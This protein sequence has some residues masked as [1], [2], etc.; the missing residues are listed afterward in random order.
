[1]QSPVNHNLLS[2]ME[3][4]IAPK[5]RMESLIMGTHVGSHVTLAM[6]WPMVL[7][8]LEIVKVMVPGVAKMAD[9]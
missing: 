8:L 6:N 7:V 1:M 9:V 5:D 2:I 4:L 3:E